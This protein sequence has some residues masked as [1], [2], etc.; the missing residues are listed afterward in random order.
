MSKK[1]WGSMGGSLLKKV[2]GLAIALTLI[3]TTFV[4]TPANAA[5]NAE[6]KIHCMNRVMYYGNLR[7]SEISETAANNACQNASTAPESSYISSCMN[8]LMYKSNTVIREKMNAV[9]AASVCQKATTPIMVQ[10][11]SKCMKDNM[12]DANGHLRRSA[13][14]NRAAKQCTFSEN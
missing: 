10:K 13:N 3:T 14:A 7:R 6:F 4:A 8:D 11:V 12:Y 2:V 1:A 5:T 9:A